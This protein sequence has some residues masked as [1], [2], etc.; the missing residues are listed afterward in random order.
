MSNGDGDI[1]CP[2]CHKCIR[3]GIYAD[4]EIRCAILGQLHLLRERHTY[5]EMAIVDSL[6]QQRATNFSCRRLSWS[7]VPSPRT[8]PL[9][10]FTKECPLCHKQMLHHSL[11]YHVSRCKGVEGEESG[12]KDGKSATP[13]T[14]PRGSSPSP[15]SALSTPRP[16]A[17]CTQRCQH[18]G[19]AVLRSSVAQHEARCQRRAAAATEGYPKPRSD[20]KPKAGTVH[21]PSPTAPCP[22]CHRLIACQGLQAHYQ[23]CK[24][25]T[26]VLEEKTR[27]TLLQN[28]RGK[29]CKKS[30]PSLSKDAGDGE[31]PLKFDTCF[32]PAPSQVSA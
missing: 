32:I 19:A 7:E 28:D 4:H 25:W 18:C 3:A 26:D 12:K 23:R 22:S 16:A 8:G 15:Q 31:A 20:A 9:K 5:Q 11:Q 2:R 27:P 1:T 29:T 13:L 10:S 6:Q 24:K 14:S 21:R 30:E 17:S